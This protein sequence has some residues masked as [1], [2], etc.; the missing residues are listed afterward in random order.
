MA[1]L[2][3]PYFQSAT[4]SARRPA[5]VVFPKAAPWRSILAVEPD[6]AVLHAKSLL[7]AKANY[8]VTRASSDREL[9]TLRGT[10]PVALAILSDHLGPRLLGTVA[11][12]VRR[13]WPRARILVLGQVPVGLEDYLYD[14]HIDRSSDSQQVLDNLEDLYRGMWNQSAQTLDWHAGR[15]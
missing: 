5:V 11:E 9:F 14:E 10:K 12:I 15:F 6:V 1:S 13:Y 2:A 8:R 3:V 4:L 7:L